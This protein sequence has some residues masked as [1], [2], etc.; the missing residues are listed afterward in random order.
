MEKPLQRALLDTDAAA[1]KTNGGELAAAT[2][3]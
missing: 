2:Q 3:A 1:R